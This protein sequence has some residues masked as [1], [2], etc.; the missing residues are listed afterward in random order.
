MTAG[1]V[2]SFEALLIRNWTP[3]I[4]RMITNT[5][6]KYVATNDFIYFSFIQK[7]ST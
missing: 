2:R 3:Q 6:E 5:T 1:D 4:P 7:M